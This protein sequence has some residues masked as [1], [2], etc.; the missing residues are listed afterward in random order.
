MN[1]YNFDKKLTELASK[2]KDEYILSKINKEIKLP[3]SDFSR[4][5][6]EA[7]LDS[8]VSRYDISLDKFDS[9]KKTKIIL[10]IY[11]QIELEPK[12]S[13][14]FYTPYIQR[15][16]FIKQL[17]FSY[18]TY[19]G[20]LHSRIEH[21]L[22]VSHLIGEFCNY[23]QKHDSNLNQEIIISAKIA[24]L[25][26]D[27]GH[28]PCGHSLELLKSCISPKK[29]QGDFRKLDKLL[30]C[31]E[32]NNNNSNIRR[33]L[34]NI[35]VNYK[36]IEQLLGCSEGINNKLMYLTDL[37]DSAIDADRL[38][39]LA[40]D[41]NHTGI[42][43]GKISDPEFYAQY[44]AISKYTDEKNNIYDRLSLCYTDDAV[45]HCIA[46][47]NARK[48]MYA[49]VYERVDRV[50]ADEMICHALYYLI[51]DFHLQK[52]TE[53]NVIIR[54]L[55]KLTD[56]ELLFILRL[57]GKKDIILLIESLFTNNLH[58]E[59]CS[60]PLNKDENPEIFYFS[61]NILING[62]EIKMKHELDFWDYLDDSIKKLIPTTELLRPGIFIYVPTFVEDAEQTIRE[63]RK[64][65]DTLICK[66]G[67]A[68]PISTD[69]RAP[70]E[71]VD[72]RTLNLRL[73]GPKIL[74]DHKKKIQADFIAFVKRRSYKE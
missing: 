54:N 67:I 23:L 68:I 37:F 32:L 26:H 9:T 65:N 21:S 12:L 7:L 43:Q 71:T 73:F 63:I 64:I 5:D 24:G 52:S 17:S 57:S 50:A 55:L 41:A 48:Y 66:D 30:I 44:A 59:I 3:K 14:I 61:R 13:Y 74:A 56:H 25:L 62:Y 51:D 46:V 10:P 19:P 35:E 69:P 33:A 8:F 53:G 11:S 1:E 70:K 29:G 40:R 47:I 36:F 34:D 72:T 6:L 49:E 22:G 28:G 2:A 27:A 16:A 42:E 45:G 60:F 18:M 15:M 4:D 20:A 38:D 31:D 39:Y 58:V